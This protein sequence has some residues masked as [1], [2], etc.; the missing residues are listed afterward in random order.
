MDPVVAYGQ[1]IANLSALVVIGWIY[2]AYVK[3]LR[4][5]LS[6]KD[7]QLASVRANLALWKD[8]AEQLEKKTPEYLERLLSERIRIREEELS[9]LKSD[10][11]QHQQEIQDRNLELEKL[12]YELQK[13]KDVGYSI[14]IWDRDK[15]QERILEPSELEL[16]KLGEVYVDAACLMICDPGYIPKVWR[17]YDRDD[18]P[19]TPARF[20]DTKDGEI[21]EQGRDFTDY[22][23]PLT[24]DPEMTDIPPNVSVKF[25]LDTGRLERI[26]DPPPPPP[27]PM[28]LQGA[29]QASCSAD[30]YGTLTFLTGAE[31]AGIC[32]STY[33]GDGTFAVYGEKFK[34]RLVRV[35][36]NLL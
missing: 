30:R 8:K 15:D 25:L 18:Y 20:M 16:V 12:K 1:L 4:A 32:F 5:G 24:I 22:G 2:A 35:Y 13:A 36:V 19:K 34:D 3:N 29:V 27:Y 23:S 10:K 21:Y 28:S 14:T 11:E 9:R 26:A 7:E 6:L 33:Y 31:G 17:D